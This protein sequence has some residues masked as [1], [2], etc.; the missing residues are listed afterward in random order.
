IPSRSYTKSHISDYLFEFIWRWQNKD[1]LW[2]NM[3][4]CM[5]NT[6]Y[7]DEKVDET[8]E[9]NEDE[10]DKEDKENE[11]E[12]NGRNKEG[13]IKRKRS[14]RMRMIRMMKRRMKRG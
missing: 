1:N 3:L 12:R 8:D 7:F 9:E 6:G 2:E 11:K 4:E 5:K 14:M 13:R 10:K